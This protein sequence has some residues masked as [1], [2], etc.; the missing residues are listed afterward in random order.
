MPTVTAKPKLPIPRVAIAGSALA[1][2]A[3]AGALA[4]APAPSSTGHS[5]LPVEMLTFLAVA[6]VCTAVLARAVQ[7]ARSGRGAWFGVLGLIAIAVGVLW[8]IQ[9]ANHNEYAA[10]PGLAAWTG[11][12]LIAAG[13]L[14]LKRSRRSTP[15]QSLSSGP[16]SAA[17]ERV[18]YVAA[19]MLVGSALLLVA[20]LFTN[21][22][23]PG[24]VLTDGLG[25]Q[26][27]MLAAIAGVILWSLGRASK[28][29][30]APADLRT[31]Q[32]G[33][34]LHDSVLQE[35]AVIR[36]SADDPEAVRSIARRTE[37]DLRDWLSGSDQASDSSFAAAIKAVARQVED[38]VPGVEIEV[39]GV[40]DVALS[41]RTE[42]LVAATREATRNAARHGSPTVRL[43]T[44]VAENGSITVFVRDTGTGFT[45]DDVPNERRG[46]RDAI[47]GRMQS[48]GG[49]AEI[50]SGPDGTEV[51]LRLPAPEQGP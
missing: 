33:A 23:V 15:W 43:F 47:I 41:P 35:L 19:P 13:L 5:W 22:L 25:W 8:G 49:T 18:V 37:R 45:L 6:L 27:V 7:M 32:V 39:I 10:L 20:V 9:V 3:L 51:T 28:S 34:H 48:V 46:V 14:R 36:R 12:L 42:T 21:S 1:C 4:K 11:W 44:E 38:E 50:E 29:F 40:R 17:A 2:A 26:R 30:G 24:A 16:S 31:Q